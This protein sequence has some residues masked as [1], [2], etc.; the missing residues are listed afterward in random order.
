MMRLVTSLDQLVRAVQDS[1]RSEAEVVAV[2]TV[3]LGSRRAA[4]VRNVRALLD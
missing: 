2:L 4:F 1:A 3:L